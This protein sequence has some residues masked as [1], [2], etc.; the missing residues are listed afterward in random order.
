M[1]SDFVRGAR[2]AMSGFKLMTRPQIRTF[3]AIPLFINIAIFASIF[4]LV[5]GQIDILITVLMSYLPGWLD[6]ISWFVLAL[7][8]ILFL[9]ITFY[10][11]TLIANLVGSPFNSVLSEKLEE[12][13]SGYKAPSSGRV[14]DSVLGIR[15]AVFAE[16]R[17]LGYLIGWSVILLILTFIPPITV[18]STFLWF[19]FGAWM[20]SLEYM[21]YPMG[22]HNIDFAEQRKRQRINRPM[23]MGFGCVLM[24]FTMIPFL[25]FFVMP[26]GVAAATRLWVDEYSINRNVKKPKA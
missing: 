12:Q 17:K 13:L 21:D 14:L 22:N 25:N 11:F 6:W 9:V 1:I 4:F 10:T 16:F 8:Y 19:L 24:L 15:K 20:L 7:F 26:A 2:Y 23:S 3:V 18:I 5:Q